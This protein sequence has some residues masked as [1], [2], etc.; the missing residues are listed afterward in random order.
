M[1][2]TT[3]LIQDIRNLDNTITLFHDK[4]NADKTIFNNEL[5]H[6]L[7]QFS[8]KLKSLEQIWCK[9]VTA[10]LNDFTNLSIS[11]TSSV[12]GLECSKSTL[13]QIKQEYPS[14]TEKEY[15]NLTNLHYFNGSAIIKN[16]NFG[17]TCLICRQESPNEQSLFDHIKTQ[18]HLANISDHFKIASLNV[19]SKFWT[20]Q[21]SDYRNKYIT[22][23]H[24]MTEIY[25]SACSLVL[26]FDTLHG[27]G[28]FLFDSHRS[29][30]LYNDLLNDIAKWN[31]LKTN[32]LTLQDKDVC[33]FSNYISD[34]QDILKLGYLEKKL[35]EKNYPRRILNKLS[36]FHKKHL[37]QEIRKEK[38]E[39]GI[40]SQQDCNDTATNSKMEIN[41]VNNESSRDTILQIYNQHYYCLTCNKFL[42][43][44]NVLD[45]SSSKR[46]TNTFTSLNLKIND[47]FCCLF[48]KRIFYEAPAFR[49]HAD[50]Q[51]HKNLN[52]IEKECPI[53]K[54]KL[55]GSLADIN[56]HEH[57][58]IVPACNQVCKTKEENVVNSDLSIEIN[59]LEME[60][61]ALHPMNSLAIYNTNIYFNCLLCR[62]HIPKREQVW[63]H[64]KG[65]KHRNEITKKDKLNMLNSFINLISLFLKEDIDYNIYS[66]RDF[67]FPCTDKT[68]YCKACHQVIPAQ[69]NKMNLHFE[70]PAHIDFCNLLT[71]N[72]LGQKKCSAIPTGGHFLKN[73]I[74]KAFKVI[75]QEIKSNPLW[76]FET[77]CKFWEIP[78]C[79][80]VSSTKIDIFD[81]DPDLKSNTEHK[82]TPLTQSA[83]NFQTKLDLKTS[84]INYPSGEETIMELGDIII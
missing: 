44:C 10:E 68:V 48:C 80:K 29:S 30:R 60:M 14:F 8:E 61:N 49:A 70:S 7:Q 26:P 24:S 43:F 23:P 11:N 4:Y 20:N 79:A 77:K 47:I 82:S 21:R 22:W 67:I 65:V 12:N 40:K 28:H 54:I 59:A 64:L 18:R 19:F 51:F 13:Q 50:S 32:E 37:I 78:T 57:F 16:F 56:M 35:L 83:S 72:A 45:H 17:Y 38:I 27:N 33:K 81:C 42:Q 76:L 6:N 46:H 31:R 52:F 69:L 34:N 74:N 71:V 58:N 75:P 55:F 62:V 41:L 15:F 3:K 66:N 9:D 25:C 2:I 53:C 63:T 5:R 73:I 84:E 36:L 1:D 39:K